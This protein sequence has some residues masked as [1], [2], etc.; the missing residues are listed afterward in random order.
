MAYSKRLKSDPI[1]VSNLQD[2]INALFTGESPNELLQSTTTKTNM[3]KFYA[4]DGYN[5]FKDFDR[6]IKSHTK[7]VNK[8]EKLTE[9]IK[10]N[11][12]ETHPHSAYSIFLKE[13]N[14]EYK[15]KNPDMSPKELRTFMTKE[16]GTMTDKAKKP[17]ESSYQKQKDSF[18][19]SVRQIDPE[20]VGLFDKSLAPKA[21][22]RPYTMFV[23]EQM[24]VIRSENTDITNKAV[25]KLAGEKWR[26]MSESDKKK[27]YDKC[28]VEMPV[29]LKPIK[30]KTKKVE[31]DTEDDEKPKPT[32]T[33]SKK[34]ES[35]TEDDEKS[36]PT[37]AKSKKVDSDSEDDHKSKSTKAKSKKV[38]SDSEDE[39]T[40]TPKK[41]NDAVIKSKGKSALDT[42]LSNSDQ[43]DSD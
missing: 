27:Y 5:S 17:F 34:V 1:F 7:R 26:S 16:W 3:L 11:K 14:A 32:K 18:I 13:K 22:P 20:Y 23:T 37:K 8:K 6:S 40:P 2:F 33:K 24:K 29:D 4:G 43:S 31:S 19:E 42:V 12:L 10:S 36:K 30:P 41:K 15:K 21:A 35:D 25:M 28:G 38:E 39:P 9:F